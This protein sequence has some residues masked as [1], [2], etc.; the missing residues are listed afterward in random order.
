MANK[1]PNWFQPDI[2]SSYLDFGKYYDGSKLW[3]KVAKVAKAAGLKAI[4][5]V[6][7]LY[8]VSVD[9]A[10][11]WKAKAIIYGALGYFVLPLD[12]IPDAL[13][14]VG[15]TDDI[16]AL[17]AAL[18]AVWDYITPTTHERAFERLH[19]WFPDATHD[20]VRDILNF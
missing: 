17:G 14:V 19:A 5:A 2:A 15:F 20:E 3:N 12:F 13:P 11:P 4:Y 6:L 7:L 1:F 8:F 10:T 16:T 18:R 9:P